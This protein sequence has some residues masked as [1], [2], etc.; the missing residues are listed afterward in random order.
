MRYINKSNRCI[1][2]DDFV[3]KN[4]GRLRN[5]WERFKKVDNDGSVR[6]SLHQHLW[7]DQKGLCCYCEQGM[8]E[9]TELEEK[10]K[11]QF[12]HIRAKKAKKGFPHLTYEFDNIILSCEGFDLTDYL[13]DNKNKRQFCGHIK[14][15]TVGGINK[16]NDTLFLNPTEIADIE[17][18]F[19][20][21]SEGNIEP[22]P[23]KT[24]DEQHRAAYMIRTLAL[25]HPDLIGMRQREFSFWDAKRESSSYEEI[26]AELDENLPLL[27]SFF[28]LLK[29]RFL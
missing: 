5:E 22:H 23:S 12:E 8:P 14:D 20:F 13:V 7:Y 15:R 9:K 2:F 19:R 3:N 29:Q 28:S 27:P 24:E 6:L 26:V 21:D 16:Y 18:Y 25:D 4:R 11:S 17:S 1:V 10:P